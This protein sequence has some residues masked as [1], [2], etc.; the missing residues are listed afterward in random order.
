MKIE[1][2]RKHLREHGKEADRDAEIVERLMSIRAVLEQIKQDMLHGASEDDYDDH[3]DADNAPAAVMKKTGTDN[4]VRASGTV[5]RGAGTKPSPTAATPAVRSATA[6][7]AG[8]DG[9]LETAEQPAGGTDTRETAAEKD[10]RY[11]TDGGVLTVS[12][13]MKDEEE[14]GEKPPFKEQMLFE[15]VSGHEELNVDAM[16]NSFIA[17]NYDEEAD[18]EKPV[19]DP[20]AGLDENEAGKPHREDDA[21][22]PTVIEQTLF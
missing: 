20:F 9:A 13:V 8:S 4:G 14:N 21:P 10:E 22:R 17:K 2:A 1:V 18:R 5:R 19:V 3:R 12:D 15:I 7:P 11:D 16:I 6:Q